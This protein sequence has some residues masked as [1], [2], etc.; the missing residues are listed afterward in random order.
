MIEL[1]H[2]AKYRVYI[3]YVYIISGTLNIYY[4]TPK[5]SLRYKILK[6]LSFLYCL[7]QN[8]II[9]SHISA[10]C[11]EETVGA[12]LLHLAMETS[13]RNQMTGLQRTLGDLTQQLNDMST[14]VQTL[15]AKVYSN[16][17]DDAK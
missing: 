1:Y 17:H 15:Q 14:T 13:L 3:V 7:I 16:E 11:T 2:Y 10:Y 5:Q 4:L 6:I 9:Y 8:L 12:L